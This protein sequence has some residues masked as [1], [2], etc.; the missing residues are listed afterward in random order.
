M[1]S[2]DVIKDQILW[3]NQHLRIDGWNYK[4]IKRHSSSE[5]QIKTL[6]FLQRKRAEFEQLFF[7]SWSV[8]STSQTH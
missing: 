8:K 3:N 4:D 5:R 6:E 2:R 7:D 1:T